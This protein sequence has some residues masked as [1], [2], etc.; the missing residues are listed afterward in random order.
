M[1]DVRSV[2]LAPGDAAYIKEKGLSISALL[3][4]AIAK[5][6]KGEAPVNLDELV[7]KIQKYSIRY[8][9]ALK[10]MEDN[11]IIQR[12]LEQKAGDTTELKRIREISQADDRDR[13]RLTEVSQ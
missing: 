10:F 1:S 8:D 13:R 11:G 4:V 9:E 6:R 12:F 3:R 5:H 2:S 7:T